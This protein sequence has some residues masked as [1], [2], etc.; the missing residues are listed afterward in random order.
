MCKNIFITGGCGYKGSKIVPLLLDNG[1]KV[2]VYDTTWFGN[3]LQFHPDLTV[4]IGDVRNLENLSLIGFDTVIHL[5]SIAN[6]PCGDLN[7]ALTWEISVLATQQLA[8]IAVS[9]GVKDF[10]Y[11]SS[12]SVYG[13]SHAENVTENEILVPISTY[14]KTKMCAERVLLSYSEQINIKI[15]RPATVCG[16]S[17]RMRLDVAVNMLTIQ[18]LQNKEITVLGGEQIRPNIHI[19]DL[20]AL[21]AFFVNSD[22]KLNGIYN[23]GFE[24]LK[25]I[26][27]A[28]M[29]VSE[30]EAQIIIKKS[31]DPRSYRLCSDK[32]LNIGFKPKKTVLDA[33]SEISEAWKVGALVNKPEWH[34]VNWMQKLNL[35]PE[36][37]LNEFSKTA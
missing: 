19:D 29:I 1:H 9:C 11:A 37:I 23:A 30:T 13:L 10:I 36:K 17:S 20:A 7:P 32:L 4:L 26:D 3:H 24:N 25:I 27:I 14:N 16:L 8:E 12:G 15:I 34:T 6:D 18:A 28:K 21:Y 33:I 5:A 22:K 31:N 35:G 2:T